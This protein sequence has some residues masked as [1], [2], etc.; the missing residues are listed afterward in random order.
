MQQGF[1]KQVP[2]DE[3]VQRYGKGTVSRL[4]LI[5]KD[6]PDGSRKRHIVI[7]PRR[8]QGNARAQIEERIILPRA[9]DV[10]TMCRNMKSKEGEIA[11]AQ[12]AG[13]PTWKI[14]QPPQSKSS[15]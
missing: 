3:V 15:C 4:A 1:V 8:S 5:V 9:Q 12:D 13:V 11:K 2:W 6:R 10:V 7:D 14:G